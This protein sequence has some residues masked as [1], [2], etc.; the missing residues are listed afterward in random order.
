MKFSSQEFSLENFHESIHLTNNSV[1]RFYANG[2]RSDALPRENMWSLSE[3]LNYLKFQKKENDWEA[4]IFPKIKENI[5]AVLLGEF[6]RCKSN[7]YLIGFF[8]SKSRRY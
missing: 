5:L 3:F 4:Y 8:Y 1:Q 7:K 6:F 2:E